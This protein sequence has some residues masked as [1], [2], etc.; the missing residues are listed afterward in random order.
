MRALP[1]WRKPAGRPCP[2]FDT[3]ESVSGH[4]HF[5]LAWPLGAKRHAQEVII[6]LN[7]AVVAPWPIDQCS[8]VSP[9]SAK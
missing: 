5:V 8:N 3:D 6:K 4:V 9:I 1:S 2:T 7:G